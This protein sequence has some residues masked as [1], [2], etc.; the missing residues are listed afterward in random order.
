MSKSETRAYAFRIT[1]GAM[2]PLPVEGRNFLIQSC[3]GPV[4]V[5][6]PNGYMGNLL[7]GQGQEVPEG[8]SRL[9]LT[10]TGIVDVFGV[11]LISNDQFIDKRITGEVSVIDGEMTR[12]LTGGG[13]MGTVSYGSG[14][15][16]AAVQLWNQSA[17]KNLIVTGVSMSID[18]V[19]SVTMYGSDTI[20]A[21]GAATSANALI[22][23]AASPSAL[24]RA[25]AF[26]PWPA[27]PYHALAATTLAAG[28]LAQ[29]ALTRPLVVPPGKGLSLIAAPVS[30][31]VIGNF[32]W[33]EETTV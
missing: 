6:W 1:P 20:L 15:N 16:Y 28:A 3:S 4:N 22:A 5:R 33:F 24:L 2:F 9:D 19:G 11:V 17:D 8:F 32:Q 29:I 23:A 13:F 27:M 30:A 26:G 21:I 18:V 31:N 14:G 7:A 12:T 25:Q 10:N